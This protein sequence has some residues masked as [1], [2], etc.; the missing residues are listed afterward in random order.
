MTYSGDWK[1]FTGNELGALLGWW[2]WT[3]A[4]KKGQDPKTAAM[5]SSTVSSKILQTIGQREGFLFEETLTGFKW[6]ANRG[7]QLQKE[8][9]K[10]L[11]AFEGDQSVTMPLL[12]LHNSFRFSPSIEAIGFM[13]GIHVP[14]KD[15]VSAAAHLAEL[16]VYLENQ[17]STLSD[18][19]QE[20]YKK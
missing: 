17:G 4:E 9:Y 18:Q 7:L 11:F 14:D 10:I 20:I 12:A 15:G 16:A 3:K 8:G 19:L 1:V 6:M 2:M 5:I 13:C